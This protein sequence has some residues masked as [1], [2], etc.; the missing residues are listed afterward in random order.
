MLRRR[1]GKVRNDG[2][3]SGEGGRKVRKYEDGKAIYKCFSDILK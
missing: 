1:G 3:E 2:E